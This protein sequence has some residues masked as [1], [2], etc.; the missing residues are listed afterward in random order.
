MTNTILITL[1][2]TELQQI[3]KTAGRNSFKKRFKKFCIQYTA[4]KFCIQY[5]ARLEET[6]HAKLGHP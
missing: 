3:Q 4:K 6:I 5:I 1:T 2:D